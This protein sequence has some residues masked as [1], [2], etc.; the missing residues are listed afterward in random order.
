LVSAYPNVV[1]SGTTEETLYSY[2][3]PANT[4]ATSGDRIVIEPLWRTLGSVGT[5]SVR[6]RIAGM[7]TIKYKETAAGYTLDGRVTVVRSGADTQRVDAFV[8]RDGIAVSAS[9]GL[10]YSED[11]DAG[12]TVTVTG[13][14]A[15]AGDIRLESLVITYYSAN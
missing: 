7:Q 10:S 2:T 4:L 8:Y 15:T 5:R 6:V 3:I 13:E 1:T 12:I 14:S 9:L 11:E